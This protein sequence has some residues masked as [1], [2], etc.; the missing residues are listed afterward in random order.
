MLLEVLPIPSAPLLQVLE[1][2]PIPLGR[3]QGLLPLGKA[4]VRKACHTGGLADPV[5]D[6]RHLQGAEARG[7][8]CSP[9]PLLGL[10]ILSS[11]AL[12]CLGAARVSLVFGQGL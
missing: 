11:E 4:L 5:E 7:Q 9:T 8:S 2:L 10:L 3:F 12:G 1:G 6:L